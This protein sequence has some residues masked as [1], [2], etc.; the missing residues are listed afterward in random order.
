MF[1]FIATILLF[2]LIWLLIKPL[3]VNYARRKYQEK[4]N[5]MFS[6]AFGQAAGNRRDRYSAPRAKQKHKVF[7]KD[8][9]EYVEFEEIE[10]K[11]E[12]HSNDP[13]NSTHTPPNY[14]PREPQVSD[15]DWEEID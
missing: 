12:F 8:E 9:G 5:D 2:Y 11:E 1:T 10:I 4:V 7:S 6:Q 3:L 14:T 15:A 13:V